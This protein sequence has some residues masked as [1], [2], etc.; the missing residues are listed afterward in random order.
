MAGRDPIRPISEGNGT[1]HTV[2]CQT[3]IDKGQPKVDEA[4]IELAHQLHAAIRH[5]T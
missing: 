4:R 3:R 2:A 5:D 1:E